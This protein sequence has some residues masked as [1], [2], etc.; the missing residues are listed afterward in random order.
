MECLSH[1][2]GCHCRQ[3]IAEL[4]SPPRQLKDSQS[5][6]DDEIK[7]KASQPANER[8]GGYHH[9]IAIHGVTHDSGPIGG[10]TSQDDQSTFPCNAAASFTTS[11]E[12]GQY[13]HVQG[14]VQGSH[15]SQYALLDHA[16]KMPSSRA[17]WPLQNATPR[18]ST[19]SR[20]GTLDSTSQHASKSDNERDSD[21][22]HEREKKMFARID[23]LTIPARDLA[24]L[25]HHPAAEKDFQHD[26]SLVSDSL[27]AHDANEESGAHGD[28]EISHNPPAIETLLMALRDTAPAQTVEDRLLGNFPRRITTPE[29]V[30][31]RRSF[32]NTPH[33]SHPT[34]DPE[35]SLPI[36]NSQGARNRPEL[37]QS[38]SNFVNSCLRDR[39]P[40]VIRIV[41]TVVVLIG[42]GVSAVVVMAVHYADPA[43]YRPTTMIA[44]V[45]LAFTYVAV[46]GIFF[47]SAPVARYDD[48]VEFDNLAGGVRGGPSPSVLSS[49]TE[50]T[51]PVPVRLGPR[52]EVRI[53]SGPRPLTPFPAAAIAIPAVLPPAGA[54]P[55]RLVD[56]VGSDQSTLAN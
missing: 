16:A 51:I 4:S 35:D 14:S 55:P 11:S 43:K 21:D 42:L 6:S 47:A 27:P 5:G 23:S 46:A 22:F 25:A 39:N 18:G 3:C 7:I 10:S 41:V 13:F 24:V 54:R 33:A 32:F 44:P 26:Q 48:G 28:Q 31:I 52:V 20:S 45:V 9:D 2:K 15:L 53:R 56:S 8:G 12:Q 49:S 29:L 1:A 19:A 37:C 17:R 38:L 40:R 30:N 36:L 50:L 34:E